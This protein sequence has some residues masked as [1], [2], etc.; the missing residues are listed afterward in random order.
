L[1]S[2]EFLQSEAMKIAKN[3]DSISSFKNE[4]EVLLEYTNM[5][6]DKLNVYHIFD[7]FDSYSWSQID[8]REI[9]NNMEC[10]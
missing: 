6:N 4:I 2:D 7:S 8:W 10:E 3:C 1:N 9:K 5:Y